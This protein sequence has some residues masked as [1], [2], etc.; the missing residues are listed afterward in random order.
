MR[1]RYW[2]VAE[3]QQLFKARHHPTK[4][5]KIEIVAVGKAPV[6]LLDAELRIYRANKLTE[7]KVLFDDRD[8]VQDVQDEIRNVE[9]MNDQVIVTT[10]GTF[11]APQLKVPVGRE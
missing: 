9:V 2:Q 5:F 10:R 7:R 4:R 3:R 8:A 6:G 1:L 11:T